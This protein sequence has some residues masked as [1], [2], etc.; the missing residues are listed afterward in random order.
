MLYDKHYKA[1]YLFIFHR[2]Y[3]KEITADLTSQVFL[4]AL[5]NLKTFKYKNVPFKAWLMRIASNEVGQY[6]RNQFWKIKIYP[7]VYIT[8]PI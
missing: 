6:Y 5:I 7:A 1:I 4:K 2:I 8:I 3:D